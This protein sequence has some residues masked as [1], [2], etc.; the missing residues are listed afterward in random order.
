ME[1]IIASGDRVYR[2]ASTI[3][4][5][6]KC[7]ESKRPTGEL[8]FYVCVPKKRKKVEK[9]DCWRELRAI[10]C[11][12]SP[13]CAGISSGN[14]TKVPRPSAKQRLDPATSGISGLTVKRWIYF[15]LTQILNK[16]T[17]KWK[18]P[19]Q[20]TPK[21]ESQE[22]ASMSASEIRPCC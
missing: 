16:G 8:L 2:Y 11:P 6:K 1:A 13:P 22:K 18:I 10:I 21:M 3:R 19:P 17:N 15:I 5:S 20:K 9:E 14:E 12:E 7:K 4:R